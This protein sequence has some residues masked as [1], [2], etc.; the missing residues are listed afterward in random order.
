MVVLDPNLYLNGK[1]YLKYLGNNIPLL[2]IDTKL[3]FTRI[4]GYRLENLT[5]NLL[6]NFRLHNNL[7]IALSLTSTSIYVL[8]STWREHQNSFFSITNILVDN[9]QTF[10]KGTLSFCNDIDDNNRYIEPYSFDLI[11]QNTETFINRLKS[12]GLLVTDFRNKLN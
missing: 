12:D 11:F 5:E 9:N 8:E 10:I 3:H 4:F 7:E 6:F 2:Q 1:L